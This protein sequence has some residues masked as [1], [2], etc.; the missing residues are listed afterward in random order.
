MPIN[1]PLPEAP[2]DSG[3]WSGPQVVL[4]SVVSLGVPAFAFAAW[5]FPAPLV[6]PAFSVVAVMAASCVAALAWTQPH[7]P[8]AQRI[9]YWD[10]AGALAF[11][12]AGAALLS[13]PEQAMP[14]LEA[15]AR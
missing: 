13:D 2:R 11:I 15:R 8:R 5:T 4:S 7:R 12:G 10:I 6:L 1:I 9:T 3:A 14:L